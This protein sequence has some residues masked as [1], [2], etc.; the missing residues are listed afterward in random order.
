MERFGLL[1]GLALSACGGS[2]LVDD[3]VHRDPR[4]P[5]SLPVDGSPC[6]SANLGAWCEQDG[7]AFGRNTVVT[8]CGSTRLASPPTWRVFPWNVVTANP[9]GCPPSWAQASTQSV[10][11]ANGD[12]QTSLACEYD[13]GRCA[14]ACSA[15]TPGWRCRARS[16]V[17]ATNTPG[18]PVARPLTGDGCAPVGATCYYDTEVCTPDLL[19][20]GPN[21]GCTKDGYWSPSPNGCGDAGSGGTPPGC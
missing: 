16:D 20:F 18:C 14:C 21:M 6:T 7:D 15:G 5:T 19:G 12:L 1:L 17:P 10:A 13:E 2:G 3:R 9:A 8:S 11:C 4:C